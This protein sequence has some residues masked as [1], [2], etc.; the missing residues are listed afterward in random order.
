MYELWTEDSN[1]TLVKV[2]LEPIL[3]INFTFSYSN[4]T[5]VKVKYNPAF[6]CCFSYTNSNT[7]LVK[8]KCKIYLLF[9]LFIIIQ[10]QLLLKLNGIGRGWLEKFAKFK[11]NSC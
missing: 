6:Q 8:V 10:I 4:T 2:K 7:T 11:Y 5:L 9:S 3:F 1:T